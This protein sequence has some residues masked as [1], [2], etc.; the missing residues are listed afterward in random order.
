M[1]AP[2]KKIV[3]P[4]CGESFSTAWKKCPVCFA[5][6]GNAPQIIV[7]N[8]TSPANPS[9]KRTAP[10]R[11]QGDDAHVQNVNFN[12]PTAADPQRQNAQRQNSP[13]QEPPKH[14]PQKQGP[15]ARANMP[16]HGT[17]PPADDQANWPPMATTHVPFINAV[18]LQPNAPAGPPPA[19][20]TRSEM[21]LAVPSSPNTL[22]RN[23]GGSWASWAGRSTI[24]RRAAE[25][26]GQDDVPQPPTAAELRA[27]WIRT[28]AATLAMGLV[29]CATVVGIVTYI[30]QNP[31]IPTAAQWLADQRRH[32]KTDAERLQW[33]IEALQQDN[34]LVADQAI[35]EMSR[36]GAAAFSPLV[37]LLRTGRSDVQYRAARAIGEMGPAAA[38]IVPALVEQLGSVDLVLR[39]LAGEALVSIGPASA[40]DLSRA[41]DAQR[42]AAIKNEYIM[43]LANLGKG[44]APAQPS[45]LKALQIEP[46]AASAVLALGAIGP[47][48]V[49]PVTKLL[50]AKE[51]RVQRSACAVLKMLGPDAA[52]ALP[53]LR[54]TLFSPYPAVAE[55]VVGVLAQLGPVATPV[56][57]EALSSPHQKVQEAA[58]TALGRMGADVVAPVVVVLN[59]K[60]GSSRWY[61]ART[62]GLIGPAAKSAEGAL[63]TA[64]ASGDETLKYYCTEAL[65]KLH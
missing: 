47:S 31:P 33:Q 6:L 44:A 10:G 11:P 26:Q 1:N 3:C 58:S 7:S 2:A 14:N 8:T 23:S 16:A 49:P 46:T 36:E 62:L 52:P 53:E 20:P 55:D 48:V 18:P 34:I 40:P 27:R 63:R 24:I 61:A 42:N 37:S 38:P 35:V 13:K 45:L 57:I 41:L 43:V 50:S 25:L 54:Q 29:V 9:P 65:K 30:Q 12:L 59:S 21:A 5:D 17:Q 60:T 64:Q 28:V 22:S 4:K 15:A 56:L 39:K 32:S 19:V 51:P